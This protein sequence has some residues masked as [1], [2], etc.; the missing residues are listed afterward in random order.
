MPNRMSS[1]IASVTFCAAMSLAAP[2]SAQ[3]F[4]PAAS[5]MFRE[6]QQQANDLA[7]YMYLLKATSKLPKA[8]QQLALQMFASVEN[9][10]GLYN[11]ACSTFR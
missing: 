1:R 11:E 5:T 8:D 10:L 3:N 9:E 2:S 4:S 7:R 6:A